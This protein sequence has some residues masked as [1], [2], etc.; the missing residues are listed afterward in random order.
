VSTSGNEAVDLI[1][2]NNWAMPEG[3]KFLPN[4][5]QHTRGVLAFNLLGFDGSGTDVDG[6]VAG[7]SE[8]GAVAAVFFAFCASVFSVTAA[9]RFS[10]TAKS[11]V[12]GDK[13]AEGASGRRPPLAAP[14]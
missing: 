6:S 9:L 8:A 5:V 14:T 4:T 3:C 7:A 1:A 10:S 2:N 12:A 13:M 11:A